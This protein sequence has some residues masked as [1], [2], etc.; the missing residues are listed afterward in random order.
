MNGPSIIFMGVILACLYGLIAFSMMK[1]GLHFTI[2]AALVIALIIALASL[3]IEP[4]GPG[5]YGPGPT[6]PY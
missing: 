4:T 6:D 1:K 3:F 2:A 5:E